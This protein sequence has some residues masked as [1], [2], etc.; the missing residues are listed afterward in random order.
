MVL[1]EHQLSHWHTPRIVEMTPRDHCAASKT[2]RKKW[3]T[4]RLKEVPGVVPIAVTEL[5]PYDGK[6]IGKIIKQDGSV[7][8][9][10]KTVAYWRQN[11]TLILP[12]IPSVFEYLCE[13]RTRNICLIRGAPANIERKKTRRQKAHVIHRN[14][15][16]GDHG[17]DDEPS[18]L[19]FLDVDGV[20][21]RWRANPERAVRSI[22]KR[23]GAPWS[24][25][26]FVWFFSA[27]H[28][29]KFDKEKRWHGELSDD[30]VRVRIGFITK[31]A[32]NEAEANTLTK[33]AR[34]R[35]LELDPAVVRLVQPNYITRP[36]WEGHPGCDVL[37]DIPTIGWVQGA[38][39]YLVVPDNLAH[40]TKWARA[41]TA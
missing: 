8:P 38:Q 32:L 15:D 12:T 31:R 6:F 3:S 27:T 17:F 34:E 26:S 16:R 33:A 4:P 37:G 20:A 24:D 11:V 13:A 25:T 39:E 18:R 19:L 41:W 5:Q 7:V 36:K 21:M 23:L 29:L 35:V 30:R 2:R 14:K 28:G 9:Y 1:A 40:K 22:V 10:P